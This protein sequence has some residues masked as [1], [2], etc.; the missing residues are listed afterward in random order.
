M[1]EPSEIWEPDAVTRHVRIY[2]GPRVKKAGLK[3][4]NTI[5]GNQWPTGNTKLNLNQ[6]DLGL[7]TRAAKSGVLRWMINRRRRLIGS[8]LREAPRE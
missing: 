4:C 1:R 8:V 3:S 2:E 6:R 7:L 5:M